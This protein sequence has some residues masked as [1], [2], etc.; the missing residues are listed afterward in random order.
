MQQPEKLITDLY[1]DADA[2]GTYL[3]ALVAVSGAPELCAE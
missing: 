1:E 3:M 2:I